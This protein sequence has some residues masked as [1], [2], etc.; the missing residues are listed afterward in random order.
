MEVTEKRLLLIAVVAMFSAAYW[1]GAVRQLLYVN[2]DMQETDQLSY[3]D[4]AEK[5][6]RSHF[7]RVP[8]YNRV[9]LYPLIQSFFLQTDM[10]ESRYFEVGKFNNVA[11]S[12]G[13]LLAF[14]VIAA[15]AIG[16]FSS[17][18]LTLLTAFE[19]FIFK[20][21]WFQ[22]ELLFY[23]LSFVLFLLMWRTL[24]RPSWS[25]AVGV[26]VTAALAH[27]TKASILPGLVLFLGVL[28]EEA[29]AELVAARRSTAST[30]LRRR[31]SGFHKLLM[32]GGIV[33]VF[34]G[35][36]SPYLLATKRDTGRFFYNVNSTFYLWYDSWPE[37]VEGTRAHG[38]HTGWP[39]LPPEQIPTPQKYLREHS[40]GQI[41]TRI[42]KGADNVLDRVRDSY[43]YHRF[44]AL[45]GV[46]VALATVARRQQV[47][48]GARENLS[49]WLFVVLYFGG[50]AL[51][52]SW[53]AAIASGNRLILGQFMPLMFCLFVALE[54][55]LGD[56]HLAVKGRSVSAASAAHFFVLILLL[57]DI[58]FVVT[59][60]VVTIIGGY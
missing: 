49:L 27:L 1:Y 6:S 42:G 57:P 46:L 28:A 43:G 24:Q 25:R 39:D 37:A 40:L 51:L 10:T 7:T 58:Y 38:D 9:P 14:G 50:Y 48:R 60:R 29:I 52:Y 20:A 34:V 44:V 3:I 26:G 22:A 33:V 55:L 11:L 12:L 2:T 13:L 45:Y 47:V 4:Y 32:A 53:Y 16:G 23:F 5:L 15:Q 17:A 36:Q 30:E 21:G 19:V 31:S 18:V 54:R 56:T 59:R 8:E 35:V 41:L